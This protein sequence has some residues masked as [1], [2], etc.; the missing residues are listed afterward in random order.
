[1]T[2]RA[3]APNLGV[4][5]H[6]CR[7]PVHLSIRA[8]V[9]EA[10]RSISSRGAVPRPHSPGRV[11]P[12]SRLSVGGRGERGHW[13]RRNRCQQDACL[14]H[15]TRRIPRAIIRGLPVAVTELGGAV[16]TWNWM[17][18]CLLQPLLAGGR[19]P[20][21]SFWRG[22]SALRAQ[23]AYD[24]NSRS[25]QRGA[26][27][28]LSAARWCA[29]RARRAHLR[30]GRRAVRARAGRGADFPAHRPALRRHRYRDERLRSQSRCWHRRN[31]L[32]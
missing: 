1:M 27:G 13:R 22:C 9:S 18:A 15:D 32:L 20:A 4:Q 26:P 3:G 17:L 23:A 21:D 28:D 25:T 5:S 31:A 30:R 29:L 24:V 6:S 7:L 12:G 8:H 2:G 14:E 10:C 19:S 11:S 16:D